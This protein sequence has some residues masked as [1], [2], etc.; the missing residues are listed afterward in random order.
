MEGILFNKLLKERDPYFAYL[1]SIFTNL[2]LISFKEKP[3]FLTIQEFK[4]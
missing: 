4:N 3:R 2:D 1:Q